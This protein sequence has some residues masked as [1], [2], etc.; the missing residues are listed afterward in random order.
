S[1]SASI[2]I[3]FHEYVDVEPYLN[4]ET[5]PTGA[6]VTSVD[7]R[8]AINEENPQSIFYEFYLSEEDAINDENEI[9][10]FYDIDNDIEEPIDIWVVARLPDNKCVNIDSFQLIMLDCELML[11][12]LDNLIIC[13]G[14]GSETFDLTVHTPVVFWNAVGYSVTYHLT[15]QDAIDYINAI[16]TAEL[17]V[18]DGEHD[19]RIWVRVTNDAN[20]YTFGITS[21]YLLRYSLP[22]INDNIPP[23]YA[24]NNGGVGS[25]NLNLAYNIILPNTNN[26]AIEFYATEAL[27][28]EG[29]PAFILP[30]SYTGAAGTIYARVTSTVTGCYVIAPLEWQLIA[31]PQTNTLA[32]LQYCDANNDGFGV[33]NLEPTKFLVAGNPIPANVLISYHET[34]ADAENNF[35]AIQNI[36]TYNNIVANQQTIYVRVGYSNST[37]YSI[38][39]LDLIVNATPEITP[40]RTL[41]QCDAGNNNV[42]FFDLTVVEDM[43]MDDTTGYTFT[44]HT[45]QANAI[46]GAAAIGN[47]TSFS[48]AVSNTILVRITN[49]ATGCYTVTVVSL[50]LDPMPFVANPLP[51]FSKCDVNGDG[52]EVFELGTL[53]PGIIGVLQG[54]DVTFHYT[55][56]DAHSGAPALPLNYQNVTPNVQTIHVRV[57]NATTGCY[58]VSTMDLRVQANPVLNIPDEP[59]V[60]CSSSGFGTDRKSTRL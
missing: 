5:C 57:T 13:G 48:N 52:F 34:L 50:V 32:P 20:I 56:A 39:E 23:L 31:P 46:I 35:L 9:S 36:N 59:Y 22:E 8:D 16:P 44:Y 55:S 49:D 40:V 4:I 38:E 6:E 37:C 41:K 19:Q 58:V 12:N 27:A 26:I 51:T 7:L 10:H 42:E 33:F 60:I 43:M 11:N 1:Q 17:P 47:P 30:T 15:E 54:L 45:T 28:E 14:D 3:E 25:F 53:I 24:C 2:L 29:N 21:F 18:Y